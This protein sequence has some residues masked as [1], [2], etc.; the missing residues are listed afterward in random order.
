VSKAAFPAGLPPGWRRIDTPTAAGRLIP[1]YH[2]PSDVQARSPI[3]FRAHTRPPHHQLLCRALAALDSE[4]QQGRNPLHVVGR[5]KDPQWP[6]P[7]A[8]GKRG[9]YRLIAALHARSVLRQTALHRMVGISHKTRAPLNGAPPMVGISRKTRAPPNGAPPMV[10]IPRKTRAP[11]NGAPPM[12]GISRKT[13][14]PP[15]GAPPNVRLRQ[16]TALD[17]ST[18]KVSCQARSHDPHLL[19]LAKRAGLQPGC[20]QG[21]GAQTRSASQGEPSQTIMVQEVNTPDRWLKPYGSWHARHRARARHRANTEALSLAL[22]SKIGQSLVTRLI[23]CEQ[24]LPAR[25]IMLQ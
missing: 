21:G 6:A 3:S 8:L 5:S 9:R 19:P 7:Q 17:R 24:Q 16:P 10:G 25:C 23:N 13:R 12:V 18:H 4:V 11:P 20:R 14:A 22:H 15:N 2:G 1:C